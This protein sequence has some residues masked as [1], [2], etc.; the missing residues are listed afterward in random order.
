MGQCNVSED[1]NLQPHFVRISDLIIGRRVANNKFIQHIFIC[2]ASINVILP[3]SVVNLETLA[4]RTLHVCRRG[5]IRSTVENVTSLCSKTSVQSRSF[6]M[7][8]IYRVIEEESTI[9]WEMIV[10][11]ILSKKSSYRHGSDFERLPRY[12]KKKIRTI[13]RARTA[14]T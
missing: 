9:L 5:W 1:L 11:V 4:V 2:C 10:C 12:G 8:R 13:L 3:T 14:I 6:V 7:A